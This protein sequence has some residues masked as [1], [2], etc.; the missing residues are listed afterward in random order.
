MYPELPKP[1]KCY[2]ISPVWRADKPQRGRYREF[3]QCDADIV[4]SDSPLAD[5][6]IVATIY[7][8]LQALNFKNFT[9]HINNRKILNG[10]ARELGID[11]HAIPALFRIIDK[12]EQ[13][14]ID[15]VREEMREKG[16]AETAVNS[17]LELYDIKNELSI[18][19]S[20][21]KNRFPHS[22]TLAKG[23][24]ELEDIFSYLASMNIQEGNYRFDLSLAR[25][26]D[27]YTGPIFET[28]V[29]EPRIGSISGG[30]RYDNLIGMF[31][32]IKKVGASV[33]LVI[34]QDHGVG[35]AVCIRGAQLGLNVAIVERE[36]MGGICLNWGC[37]PTKAMLRSAEVF[38]ASAGAALFRR[39]ALELP[40]V[41]A[42]ARDTARLC[43]Y[44]D[45][46]T[47]WYPG[48]PLDDFGGKRLL[49]TLAGDLAEQQFIKHRLGKALGRSTLA[50]DGRSTGLGRQRRAGLGMRCLCAGAQD[51]QDSWRDYGFR[52]HGDNQCTDE[53][54]CR[55]P[56]P[57][58]STPEKSSACL[59]YPKLKPCAG[60]LP[61]PLS[62]RPCW[63]PACVSRIYAG[64]CPSIWMSA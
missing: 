24:K 59:N 46:H 42:L 6:E 20:Y 21:L 22:Q 4:G 48:H 55:S 40:L 28:T 15:G 52:V 17:I 50:G 36:H 38:G 26:L 33:Q 32:A 51:R 43:D 29:D 18:N 27:Y 58:R 11:E 7:H 37:I 56:P 60:A 35:E 44:V 16:F 13:K 34:A 39:A 8:I 14:G 9:I 30:G 49:A 57:L 3:W 62:A 54:L 64:R 31:A 25:G 53:A 12:L 41:E 63:E 47:Y 23:V 45:S 10:I 61:P 5:A 1:F 2:Q 19:F